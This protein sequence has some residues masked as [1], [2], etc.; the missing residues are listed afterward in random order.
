MTATTAAHRR[1]RRFDLGRLLLYGVA[2]T[3]LLVI[4]VPLSFSII[5][6]FDNASWRPTRSAPI[7]DSE[8]P[9]DAA[10]PSFYR[11]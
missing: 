1:F 8:L 4:V 3:V 9:A 2:I 5:G 11:C 7:P 10:Y 6:G